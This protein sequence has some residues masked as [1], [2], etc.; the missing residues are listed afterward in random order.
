MHSWNCTRRRL[1]G[2]STLSRR[3]AI[4]ASCQQFQDWDAI[5]VKTD[6]WRDMVT[7]ESTD[8]MTY[9]TQCYDFARRICYWPM[10]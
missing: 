3:D 10:A 8:V 5:M 9:K 1:L 4:V 2:E 6:I 7:R